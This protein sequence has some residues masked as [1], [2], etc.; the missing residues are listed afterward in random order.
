MHGR[1]KAAEIHPYKPCKG[2]LEGFIDQLKE[3]S[4]LHGD[5]VGAVMVNDDAHSKS[6]EF[7]GDLFGKKIE[8]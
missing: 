7:Y 2:N 5:G 6:E 4:R 1:A 8:S 3:D